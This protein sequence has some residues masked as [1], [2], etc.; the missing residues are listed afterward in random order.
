[1]GFPFPQDVVKLELVLL[2]MMQGKE[3]F[4]TSESHIWISEINCLVSSGIV[5]QEVAVSKQAW[6]LCLM[7]KCSTPHMLTLNK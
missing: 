5:F 1:M 7:L 2:I 3:G 4:A 6:I